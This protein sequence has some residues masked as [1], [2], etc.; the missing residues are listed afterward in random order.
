MA[1]STCSCARSR[2][3]TYKVFCHPH[4]P[5]VLGLLDKNQAQEK[6]YSFKDI[7]P[8]LQEIGSQARA[9]NDV[10]KNE[11]AASSREKS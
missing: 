2:R 1:F 11:P 4:N 10:P 6:Y 5:D 7:E 9:A 3:D 8:F